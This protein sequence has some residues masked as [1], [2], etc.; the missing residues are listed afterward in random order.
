M[1]R[2]ALR[3]R[4]LIIAEHSYTAAF[5]ARCVRH[6]AR[7][8]R[9]LRLGFAMADAVVAVSEG[10]A[11]WLRE[12]GLVRPD[13]LQVITPISDM[14]PFA[15]IPPI[16]PHD[17]PLLG[18]LRVVGMTRAEAEAALNRRLVSA[19]WYRPGHA[20]VALLL[21]E[22]GPL[23]VT[24]SGAVFQAGRVVINQRGAP[25]SDLARQ[26]AIGV[27]RRNRAT[28]SPRC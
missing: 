23:R 24:V 10:Q 9:M 16:E 21:L 27:Q 18:A 26:S 11:A 14:A 3:G 17:G 13:R 6:R 19:G 12:A 7:F 22:R 4:R 15:A 1:L 5:E 20:R 25:D 28:R 8:R 2:M